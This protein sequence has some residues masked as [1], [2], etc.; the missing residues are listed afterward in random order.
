MKPIRLLPL[1]FCI[2][3]FTLNAQTLINKVWEQAT[4][5]PT[6]AFDHIATA[7]QGTEVF[8]VGNTYHFGEQENFLI[9]KYNTSGVM[10]W[11][12]E[13][14]SISSDR[15][16]GMDAYIKGTHLYVTGFS[17]DSASNDADLVTLKLTLDSGNIV[18]TATYAGAYG[19]YD[20][21]AG[22]R[23]DNSGNVYVAG[24]EQTGVM[25]S[26]IIVVK[27]NSSGTQSG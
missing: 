1:F 26:K 24:S 23:V 10:Q 16:F 6:I 9:T 2:S 4:G 19:G 8:I 27:Y 21:A 25:D 15:D 17:W 22:V 20:A 11:Q 18:W 13:Y 3:T 14:N 5:H 12:K 7:R